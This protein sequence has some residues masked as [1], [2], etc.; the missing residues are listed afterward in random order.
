MPIIFQVTLTISEIY[1]IMNMYCVEWKCWQRTIKYKLTEIT[2]NI[3]KFNRT[4]FQENPLILLA[5]RFSVGW[6]ILFSS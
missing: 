6:F 5:Q 3:A 4:I 2:H 1:V